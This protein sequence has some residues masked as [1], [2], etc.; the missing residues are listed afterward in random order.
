MFVFYGDG[1]CW[2][3]IA[4][5]GHGGRAIPTE[6]IIEGARPCSHNGIS[7]RISLKPKLHVKLKGI[8]SSISLKSKLRV[9]LKGYGHAS[10]NGILKR[11][12]LQPK[13]HL[14]GGARGAGYPA[15]RPSYNPKFKI[16][17]KFFKTNFIRLTKK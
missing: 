12:S 8:L 1:Y 5:G 11:I 9:K 15:I 17:L 3:F 10:H 2:L 7:K 6:M 13:L 16:K 4:G 14:A